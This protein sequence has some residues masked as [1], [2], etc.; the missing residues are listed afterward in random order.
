MKFTLL[1]FPG[2]KH[3]PELE[4]YF[5]RADLFVL[6]GTG[7]LA[8]QEAMAY[9]LP[10]IVAEGDGTQEDLVKSGNGWL[11]PANNEQELRKTL[12]EAL[13]DP[14]RLRKMGKNSIKIVQEEINIE[15][16]VKVFV[17][18]LN[19]FGSVAENIQ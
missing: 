11:I 16:M 9:G 6:P 13:V 1:E 18:A 15:Q 5:L 7:G 12:Q 2:W 19:S 4:E 17:K 10:V 3:G 8:V 14:T